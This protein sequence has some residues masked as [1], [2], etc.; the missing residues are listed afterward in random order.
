MRLFTSCNVRKTMSNGD[1]GNV[2]SRLFD[3]LF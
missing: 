2:R 3:V 1:E